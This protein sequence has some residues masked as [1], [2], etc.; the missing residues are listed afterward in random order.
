MMRATK[1][2]KLAALQRNAANIRNICMLAHVDHG[3]LLSCYTI[4]LTNISFV[5]RLHCI[6]IY[7]YVRIRPNYRTCSNKRR[8]PPFFLRS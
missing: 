8:T 6:Q 2:E 7:I 3:E 4:Q 1:T 5:V